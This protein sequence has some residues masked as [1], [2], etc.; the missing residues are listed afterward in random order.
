MGD[1]SKNFNRNEFACR[2]TR[3]C[4]G[5]APVDPRLVAGLQALRDMVG[6]PLTISSGFRCKRHNRAIGGAKD[7][8][9][10]VA[11]AADVLVPEGWTP[12]A[13]AELAES[14]DVFRTGGIGVYPTWVH[15]DVRTTGP[16]RWR[17]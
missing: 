10:T 8:L 12:G 16:A 4:G 14:I 2:C 7:S 11:M 13:F 1:L 9:H 17:P 3:S 6:K 5:S 15:V